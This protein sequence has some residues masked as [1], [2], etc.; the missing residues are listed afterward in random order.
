MGR[1]GDAEKILKEIKEDSLGEKGITDVRINNLTNVN[2]YAIVLASWRIKHQQ[3][4]NSIG[5]REQKDE[6]RRSGRLK[7][8]D[9][10]LKLL[11]NWAS[12]EGMCITGGRSIKRKEP[13]PSS[14]IVPAVV[15][16]VLMPTRKDNSRR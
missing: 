6:K 1:V 5:F 10:S 3:N 4:K 8:G 14:R 13:P 11:G 15:P 9:P 7:K 12:R 2:P 16:R